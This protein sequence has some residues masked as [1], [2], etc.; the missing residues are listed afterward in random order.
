MSAFFLFIFR[1]LLSALS[2]L[3]WLFCGFLGIRVGASVERSRIK[4]TSHNV[5][6]VHDQEGVAYELGS[7]LHTLFFIPSSSLELEPPSQEKNDES[8]REKNKKNKE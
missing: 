6:S 4:G 5:L 3:G 1:F 8:P 7:S 2:L